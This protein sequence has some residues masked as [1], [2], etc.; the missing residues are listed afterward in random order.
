[1]VFTQNL[2]YFDSK[3]IIL[4]TIVKYFY[5]KA[6]I[7]LRST[8]FF[9]SNTSCNPF[10]HCKAPHT[11]LLYYTEYVIPSPIYQ[12]TYRERFKHEEQYKWHKSQNFSLHRITRRRRKSLLPIH[13]NRHQNWP[14][15]YM[16]KRWCMPIQ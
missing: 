8:I 12:K 2:G 13:T 9:Y 14:H 11:V 7:Y 16:Q 15:T 1:M 5:I 10:Y 4:N 3:Q 6:N